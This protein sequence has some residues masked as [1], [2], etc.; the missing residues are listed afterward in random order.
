MRCGF[1][2]RG[3]GKVCLWWPRP[4]RIPG[5]TKT[6]GQR[7]FLFV[8]LLLLLIAHLPPTPT[9]GTEDFTLVFILYLSFT[10]I[11]SL[12]VD[13][14]TREQAHYPAVPQCNCQDLTQPS[15]VAGLPGRPWRGPL[16]RAAGNEIT[17]TNLHKAR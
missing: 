3:L 8:K 17:Y 16:S 12:Q 5:Q 4:P 1:T 14:N 11:S 7:T 9:P 2:I 13:G 6:R 15:P 10:P